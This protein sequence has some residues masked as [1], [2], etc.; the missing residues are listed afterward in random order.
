MS[1]DLDLLCISAMS[2]QFAGHGLLE[3]LWAAILQA[4]PAPL[5]SLPSRWGSPA[6]RFVSATPG[7][8]CSC[9][10][11]TTRGPC[12]PTKRRSDCNGTSVPSKLKFD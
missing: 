12:T 5:T 4:L 10:S 1:I 3:H 9:A 2:G 6:D 7:T 11:I 8:L